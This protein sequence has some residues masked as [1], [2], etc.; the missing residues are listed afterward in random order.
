MAVFKAPAKVVSEVLSLHTEKQQ[1]T[2]ISTIVKCLSTPILSNK[3]NNYNFEVV[4]LDS[5]SLNSEWV[6]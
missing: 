2:L 3:H 1:L 6:T 4:P 5:V